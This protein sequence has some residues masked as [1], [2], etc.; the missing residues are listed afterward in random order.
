MKIKSILQTMALA[1]TVALCNITAQAAMIEQTASVP[2]TLTDF[3]NQQF[4]PPISQFDSNL[5]VLNSVTI[6]MEGNIISTMTLDNDSPDPVNTV[7]AAT[8]ELIGNFGG[9]TLNVSPSAGTG[10]ITLNG[11]DS[12]NTDGPGDGGPDEMVFVDLAA[13]DS[14]SQT[15]GAGDD[16]SAFIGNSNLV[17]D[18]SALAGFSLSGGGGNVD[19]SV[20]TSAEATLTVIY[21]FEEDQNPQPPPVPEPSTIAF[22]AMGIMGVVGLRY[23]RRK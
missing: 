23:R 7:A 1:A 20:D 3:F 2:M 21:D 22:L 6:T 9:L 12:G 5:G 15:L 4:V 14:A 13:S 10:L 11:D 19:A 16:L 17:G 8:G 18:L